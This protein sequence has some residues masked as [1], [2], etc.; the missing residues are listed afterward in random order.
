MDESFDPEK[1]LYKDVNP[2]LKSYT[3][4]FKNYLYPS[5]GEILIRD[6]G[7]N[8]RNERHIEKIVIEGRSNWISQAQRAQKELW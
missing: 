1:Q 3:A 8:W 5:S 4:N 6:I 7:R 2:P